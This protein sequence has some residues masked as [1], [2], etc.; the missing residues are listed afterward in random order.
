MESL[1]VERIDPG[2]LL[3][4]RNAK[5]GAGSVA[6]RALPSIFGAADRTLHDAWRKL[7]IVQSTVS[8]ALSD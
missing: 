7:F 4:S 2:D 8:N 1:L 5:I 6:L 3:P